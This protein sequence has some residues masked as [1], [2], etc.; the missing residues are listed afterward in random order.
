L[1]IMVC[2]ARDVQVRIAD[3]TGLGQKVPGRKSRASA[4]DPDL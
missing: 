4:E 3:D 2:H 1:S